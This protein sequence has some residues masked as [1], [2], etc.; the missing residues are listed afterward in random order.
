MLSFK[1]DPLPVEIQSESL[2]AVLQFKYYP[3]FILYVVKVCQNL[4]LPQGVSYIKNIYTF[5]CI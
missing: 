1:S 4:S 3:I 5:K 2:V